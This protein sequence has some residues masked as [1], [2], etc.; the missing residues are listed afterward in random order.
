MITRL[1]KKCVNRVSFGFA[2]A[3][4]S[5]TGSWIA[6]FYGFY[7]FYAIIP[8]RSSKDI[9]FFLIALLIGTAVAIVT[10]LMHYGAFFRLGLKGF[11]SSVRFV[12]SYFTGSYIYTN[13]DRLDND[14]LQRLYAALIS[15][16]RNNLV[17]AT[18]YTILVILQLMVAVIIYEKDT[19][20]M[21]PIV[22]G[23]V[24]A[25]LIIGYFTFNITEYLIG[26]YKEKMESLLFYRIRT[27][28]TRY[29]M[30]FRYKSFLTL[31]LVLVSMI[32]LTILIRY[33]EKSILQIFIFISLS[34]LAIGFLIF[35]SNNTMNLALNKINR[36][37]KN[38]AA[39]GN[40]LYFPAFSDRE[41]VV[42]SKHYNNAAIEIN[43]IRANLERMVKERTDEL[44]NA[45]DRLNTAYSQTQADLLLAK[46]IQNRV[47]PRQIEKKEGLQCYIHYYP[48]NEV[49]GDF[50]HVE[51]V[52]TKL[53][54]VFIADAA[55]H[56]IQAALVTMI[57]KGEYEKVKHY[58]KTGTLM[59]NLNNSFFELY[60]S[61]NVF[62]SC[63]VID[64]D[65][66]AMQ[67]SYTSAGHPDQYLVRDGDIRRLSHTGKLVGIVPGAEYTSERIK[68][69]GGDRILLFTDGLYEEFNR[70]EEEFGEKR[71]TDLVQ[72]HGK[73]KIDMIIDAILSALARHVGFANKLSVYDD[74]TLIGIEIE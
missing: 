61:L 34:F 22:L 40:G 27:L 15:L 2:I 48:M 31:L 38:L 66:E 11:S 28:N 44:K 50:Y 42:F 64:I 26:S 53:Y 49:G 58:K 62:F 59:E 16:P 8:A 67:I 17:A 23:G 37:T 12:N 43:D 57:I 47:L 30:S 45:Y 71:L 70:E 73:E 1:F 32:I 18:L 21:G 74:I 51:E 14:T 69:A 52:D 65:L 9:L 7:L 36:A 5:T 56:G 6:A 33:S 24:F 25:A 60:E 41:L 19:S 29:F 4:F 20:T 46:K 13:H 39:G 10:H 55:G 35:L 54:R 63:F 68:L 72:A 3:L